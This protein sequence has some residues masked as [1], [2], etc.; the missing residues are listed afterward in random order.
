MTLYKILVR[1]APT[2]ASGT[3]TLAKADERALCHFERKIF[4][5]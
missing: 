3:W 2:Y 5:E 1:P 4:E